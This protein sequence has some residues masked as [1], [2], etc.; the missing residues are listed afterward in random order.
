LSES[1][2]LSCC[3]AY[4]EDVGAAAMLSKNDLISGVVRE[5]P[6]LQGIMASYYAVHEK[7]KPQV[8]EALREQYLPAHSGGV[9]PDSDVGAVLSLSDKLDTV[10]SFFCAGLIPTG[11][12]DPFALRRQTIGILSILISKR[13]PLIV[14]NLLR[15]ALEP[16]SN[17]HEEKILEGLLSF[18]ESRMEM[19]MASSGY[20]SDSIAAVIRFFRHSPPYALFEQADAIQR[21]RAD[22]GYAS[23]LLA[24][25]RVNNIAPTHQILLPSPD[26]F[27]QE[28]ERAIYHAVHS[29]NEQL[30]AFIRQCNYYD[31]LALLKTLV[32]PI[33]AFFDKVLIMDNDPAIKNNR[34][35]L[36]AMVQA[37]GQKVADFSKLS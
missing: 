8:A 22:D 19:V 21:F 29:I 31:A 11:T 36:I 2:A 1:I 18:F 7:Q 9:L 23:L 13:Y 28:E 6:E 34:L 5:F 20:P 37:L 15:K 27:M 33:H 17:G 32:E 30:E 14:T 12:E 25:K 26:L 16:F 10:A 3:P 35:S 24:L 4:K